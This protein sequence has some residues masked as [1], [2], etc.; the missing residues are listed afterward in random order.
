MLLFWF[1]ILRKAKRRWDHADLVNASESR[2]ILHNII[3]TAVE[4]N[5][6]SC[7]KCKEVATEF[8]KEGGFADDRVVLLDKSGDQMNQSDK[9]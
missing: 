8:Y 2:I 5:V 1:E 7:A 3:I 4:N 9:P 6:I